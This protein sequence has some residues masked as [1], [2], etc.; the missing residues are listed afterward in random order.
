MREEEEPVVMMMNK[1]VKELNGKW[2]N[3][4]NIVYDVLITSKYLTADMK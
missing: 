2:K 1:T 3:V 4:Q